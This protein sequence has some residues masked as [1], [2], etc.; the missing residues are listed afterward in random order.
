M[1]ITTARY[2]TP[3]GVS[4]HGKGIAP[5]IEVIMSPEEDSKLRLQKVRGD[6]TDPVEFK[7]RFGFTP[8]LDRQ[9]VTAMDALK[10]VMLINNRS[11]S[12]KTKAADG[13]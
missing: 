3:S 13:P 7:E 8:I 9:L 2:F 12:V 4:I 11:G 10:G 6:V 5:Q 1:R